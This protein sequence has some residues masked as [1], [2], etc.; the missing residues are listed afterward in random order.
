VKQVAIIGGGM[1]GIGAAR[2]CAEQGWQ[3]TLFE[4]DNLGSATSAQSLRIIHGG[5]RYL[6]GLHIGKVVDSIKA[7]NEL[8]ALYPEYIR[9]LRCIMPLRRRGLKRWPFV[10]IASVLYSLLGKISQVSQ[11]SQ[12][13]GLPRPR[14]ISAQE[15]ERSVP[16]LFGHFK[17]GAL[18]WF[19]AYVVDHQGFVSQLRQELLSLGVTL[20]DYTAVHSVTPT[21]DNCLLRTEEGGCAIQEKRFDG[22]INCSGAWIGDISVTD[23]QRVAP[24]YWCQAFNIVIKRHLNSDCA[25][26]IESPG[27]RLFFLIP[28]HGSTRVGTGYYL[29]PPGERS[30]EVAESA[31]KGF[32]ATLRCTLTSWQLEDFDILAVESGFLPAEGRR[33]NQPILT[34]YRKVGR[35]GRYIEVLSTKYT[36]FLQQGREAAEQLQRALL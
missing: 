9:P 34:T 28:E 11:V 1:S 16:D 3:V 8:C 30:D 33:D 35:S 12:Y 27:G 14:L 32:V 18:E 36:T 17:H 29:L 23:V 19:D 15:A 5:F 7:Q 2:A 21:S 13:H 31:L 6:Q 20:R 4:K 25:V 26:G 22:V 24:P 10:N